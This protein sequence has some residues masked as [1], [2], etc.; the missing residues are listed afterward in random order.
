MNRPL[1]IDIDHDLAKAKGKVKDLVD[2]LNSVFSFIQGQNKMDEHT[3]TTKTLGGDYSIRVTED[4][5]RQALQPL[6]GY[7]S[8]NPDQIRMLADLGIQFTK[9]GTLSLDEKKLD[10][11]LAKNFDGVAEFLAGDGIS[12]GLINKLER[13]LKTIAGPDNG[14]LSNQTKTYTDRIRRMQQ[15]IENKEK[16]AKQK[17]EELKNKL[18]KAQAAMN[19]LQ[20]QTAALGQLNLGAA[21]QG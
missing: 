10:A 4:R 19:N 15:D 3:D 2:H 9:E 7:S 8:D 16:G 14:V 5:I 11:Q 12:G 6:I 21:P 17:A 1:T 20:N 18:S 13:T